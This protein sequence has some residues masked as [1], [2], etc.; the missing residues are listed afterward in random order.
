VKTGI[1]LFL[2]SLATE[3]PRSIEL[4]VSP[5]IAF[6]PANL[7]IQIRVHAGPDDRWIN[8]MTDSGEFYRRSDWSIEPDRVLYRVEWKGLPA[9]EYDVRAFIGHG[10]VI[11]GRDSQT[12]QIASIGP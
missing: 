9:G 10:D 12:V 7:S 4:H 2:L 6:A 3:T 1:L 11:T 5:R 8:I